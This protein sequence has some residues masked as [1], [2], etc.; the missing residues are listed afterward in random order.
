[1]IDT[2]ERSRVRQE[3]LR[4]RKGRL[5]ELRKRY[6]TMLLGASLAVGSVGIPM[7]A[8]R[9]FLRHAEEPKAGGG[10]ITQTIP[11]DIAAAQKIAREVTGGV[12][13]AAE[14]IAAPI[15]ELEKKTFHLLTE[16]TKEEFFRTEVPFGPLIYKEAK[17]HDLD[18]TLVA[19]VVETESQFK[20]RA[21]SGANAQGLMQLVPRTGRWMGARNLM[22]PVQNVKAGTKY[23]KY[24]N[25]RFNGDQ[26]KVLAAY[27]AGEGNVR[28]FGGV[29][30]FRETRNYVR[31]VLN[32]QE[33]YEQR[34]SGKVAESLEKIT[35]T[36]A[37]A[38]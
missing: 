35:D 32:S 19:A 24:L 10:A 20:S 26:E 15:L 23:L 4:V 5:G 7:K 1:M 9:G 16:Q 13:D 18:P 12:T 11:E 22:D 3:V 36:E 29:P 38:R 30:P 14:T 33:D 37:E 21:R 27:N 2:Y 28:R 31:K 6:A 34:V 25:E 8:G 17:K